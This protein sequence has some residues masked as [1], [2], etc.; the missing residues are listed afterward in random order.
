MTMAVD[1]GEHLVAIRK[2]STNEPFRVI[3]KTWSRSYALAVV[4]K[5]RKRGYDTVLETI[6]QE[7][8]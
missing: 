1:A 8:D 5:W 3:C 4:R 6:Q 7:E 2:T